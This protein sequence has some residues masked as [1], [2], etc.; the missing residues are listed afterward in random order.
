MDL[1]SLKGKVEHP[2][3]HRGNVGAKGFKGFREKPIRTSI[4]MRVKTVRGMS[5]FKF[6]YER[7]SHAALWV[8]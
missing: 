2:S 4:L 7:V 5:D 1:V 8:W 3:Q 6:S